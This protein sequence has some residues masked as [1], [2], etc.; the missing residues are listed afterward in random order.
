MRQQ[1]S[2]FSGE[3]MQPILSKTFVAFSSNTYILTARGMLSIS[4]HCRLEYWAFV[5]HCC[6]MV[7]NLLDNNQLKFFIINIQSFVRQKHQII[8]LVPPER[9]KEI[10]KRRKREKGIERDRKYILDNFKYKMGQ[11]KDILFLPN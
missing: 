10:G 1:D 7:I 6:S 2:V 3:I 5:Q 11:G 9:G 8:Y 4:R